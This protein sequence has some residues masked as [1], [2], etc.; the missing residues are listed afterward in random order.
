MSK[1]RSQDRNKL[2]EYRGTSKDNRSK[3]NTRLDEIRRKF[4]V[5]Y[6]AYDVERFDIVELVYLGTKETSSNVN[7]GSEQQLE[8]TNNVPRIVYEL[9]ES[10]VDTTINQAV[11]Q[12][13][14]DGFGFCARMVQDKINSDISSMKDFHKDLA[15]H[16]RNTMVHGVAAMLMAWNPS[17]TGFDYIGDKE[18]INLHAKKLIPQPA[19]YRLQD[20]DYF[21]IVTSVTKQYIL[22]KY[23]ISV[24]H[25]NEEYPEVNYLENV[26]TDRDTHLTDYYSNLDPLFDKVNEIICFYKDDDGDICKYSYVGDTELEDLPKYY[27]PRVMVCDKCGTEN[28]YNSKECLKCHRKKLRTK[29]KTTEE[30]MEDEELRPLIFT[31]TKYEVI[32]DEFTGEPVLNEIKEREIVERR[33]KKGEEIPIFAP[34]MY[35]VAVRVN[36]PQNFEFKGQS[37]VEIVRDQQETIKKTM[38]I[39][40][41]LILNA[42]NIITMPEELKNQLTNKAYQIISGSVSELNQIAIHSLQAQ[43]TQY[44]EYFQVQKDI[45]FDTVGIT[46]SYQGKKD[47][48]AK[49]GVAKQVAVEQTQG[50][51]ATK[52]VNKNI[53]FKDLYTLMFYFDL[54]FTNERR[55][56]LRR[57]LDNDY[58]HNYFN[59]HEF[60]IKDKDDKWQYNTDF[61]I[62]ADNTSTLPQDNIFLFEQAIN[63][64]SAQLIDVVQFWE[65]LT[66]VSFPMSRQILEKLKAQI[67]EQ[68]RIAEEQAL[69]DEALVNAGIEN[70]LLPGAEGD[71]MAAPGVMAPL[72]AQQPP[73]PSDAEILA[74]LQQQ[75]PV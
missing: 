66:E 31:E 12:S 30:I 7:S 27:Y 50:R 38:S 74:L 29:F 43:I 68:E 71:M 9:I 39:V 58:E 1:D 11:V 3:V 34:K 5:A 51:L 72:P 52:L 40:E 61:I 53:F 25:E 56:Y 75:G 36:I 55:P 20:M 24:D 28:P 23:G 21:F 33:L 10:Q 70:E 64:Y 63:L 44:L 67:E 65:I 17:V 19:V 59:K 26:Q 14:R 42:P 4:D 54:A 49:S 22:N 73:A 13:K 2:P 69:Q 45:A 16:E 37:D 46:E 6:S 18:I 35:P 41:E 47:T 32:Q 60:L 57:N 8:Q 15:L 62:S 48:T